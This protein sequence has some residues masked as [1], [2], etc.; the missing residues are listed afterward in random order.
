[1]TEQEIDAQES[2]VHERIYLKGE[3]G[4]SF[5][6]GIFVYKQYLN[7]KGV[8]LPEDIWQDFESFT[9]NIPETKNEEA[10]DSCKKKLQQLKEALEVD[11]HI[12]EG[13]VKWDEAE[14]HPDDKKRLDG[15]K[16][17]PDME[18]FDTEKKEN[19]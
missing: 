3:T 2:D 15:S 10:I 6:I 13:E 8:K 9:I 4:I 17:T 14:I 1:M 5:D 11:K 16:Q 18:D 19:E 12:S 7:E